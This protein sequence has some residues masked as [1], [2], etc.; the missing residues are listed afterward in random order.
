MLGL[1]MALSCTNIETQL[2]PSCRDY[3]SDFG[4]NGKGWAPCSH[5][6]LNRLARGPKE[7]R[8]DGT[9]AGALSL[10]PRYVERFWQYRLAKCVHRPT[11]STALKRIPKAATRHAAYLRVPREA[12]ALVTVFEADGTNFG[13]SKCHPKVYTPTI[14][15]RLTVI[16]MDHTTP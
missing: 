9:C 10:I 2:I 5:T 1:N 4:R 8:C 3:A 6:M 15:A 11:A 12:G 7:W 16:G 13:Q 14:N